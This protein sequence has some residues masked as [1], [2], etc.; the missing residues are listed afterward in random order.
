[1]S[2]QLHVLV[3]EDDWMS[4]KLA[5]AI[6]E[7]AGHHVDTEPRPG[8]DYD[9]VLRDIPKPVREDGVLRALTARGAAQQL[10]RSVLDE[11]HRLGAD[12]GDDGLVAGLVAQFD[13]DAGARLVA[14]RDAVAAGDWT[15]VA[16]VAH[17]VKGSAAQLGGVGLAAACVGLQRAAEADGAGIGA[18]LSAVEVA[19]AR[20]RE[21]LQDELRRLA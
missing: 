21:A 14:L 5:V 8:A 1:M 17:A 11:L 18:A 10:D 7:T 16:R 6:L 4:R 12:V 20:L 3:V 19:F 9:V 2:D 15:V 13:D